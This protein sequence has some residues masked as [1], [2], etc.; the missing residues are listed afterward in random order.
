MHS[1]HLLGKGEMAGLNRSCIARVLLRVSIGRHD[2]EK[3]W[4]FATDFHIISVISDSLVG[5]YISV[6]KAYKLN[7][8][9]IIIAGET[10]FARNI[11]HIGVNIDLTEPA[12]EK[13]L[14]L[15]FDRLL[16]SFDDPSSN[17]IEDDGNKYLDSERD[18][19]IKQFA[20]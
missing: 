7:A 3:R 12:G 19:L 6:I 2:N 16:D 18:C 13:F 4:S 14:E 1:S 11:L 20:E 10:A 8:G 5:E 17:K 15:S 9:Y